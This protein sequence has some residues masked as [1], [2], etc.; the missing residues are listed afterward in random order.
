MSVCCY[1]WKLYTMPTTRRASTT[2]RALCLPRELR[3][4]LPWPSHPM[5]PPSRLPVTDHDSNHHILVC[6]GAILH[7]TTEA[8]RTAMVTCFGV[9]RAVVLDGITDL[10]GPLSGAF[11]SRH[12]REHSTNDGLFGSRRR[13]CQQGGRAR[14]AKSSRGTVCSSCLG[15][16]RSVSLS[17]CTIKRSQPSRICVF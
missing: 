3:L 16:G 2:R 1:L 7:G 15:E 17:G 5:K 13:K 9:A 4:S 11:A 6:R 12:H 8:D 14:L 10:D